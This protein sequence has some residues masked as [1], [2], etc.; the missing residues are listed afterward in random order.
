[1]PDTADNCAQ[2]ANP[3]QEDLDGDGFG[4][5]CDPDL[6]GDGRAN[7]GDCAPSDPTAADPPG[8]ATNLMLSGGAS[9]D[10]SWTA[11]PGAGSAW[12]TDVIRG[13][14]QK[15]HLDGGMTGATC[16]AMAQ[17]GPPYTDATVPPVGDGFY[18]HVR[19]RNV[20]G[21]GALG[22]ASNGSPRPAPPCP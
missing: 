17:P 8:E 6:D 16:L 4:D 19:G 21:P 13:A 5:V 11:P 14:I 20:C 9:A 18:Y 22:F 15:M 12:T 3:A 2:A 10:L 7:A 1:V